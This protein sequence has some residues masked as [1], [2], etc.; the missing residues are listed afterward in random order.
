M[1][2]AFE[3]RL[4]VQNQKA[5]VRC[6]VTVS[7]SHDAASGIVVVAPLLNL[8]AAAE[9]AAPDDFV[10]RINA[11]FSLTYSLPSDT[12]VTEEQLTAFGETNGV[13]NV[14]PYWREFVQSTSIRMGLPALTLAVFRLAGQDTVGS[15]SAGAELRSTPLKKIASSRSRARNGAK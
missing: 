7:T 14:W 11:R 6:T 4:D 1:E 15:K 2:S 12:K 9:G 5:L 3:R 13:Y 8:V 10:V